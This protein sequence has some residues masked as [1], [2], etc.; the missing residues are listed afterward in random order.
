MKGALT[1]FAQDC[2]SRLV[3]YSEAD[4]RRSEADDQVLQFVSFWRKVW[5][6]VM[7]T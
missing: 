7:P 6:G 1:L 2:D 4:I 3:L 5:R